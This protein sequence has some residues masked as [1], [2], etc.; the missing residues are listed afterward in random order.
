[1]NAKSV[2]SK[3]TGRRGW[4]YRFTDPARGG[5][6]HKVIWMTERREADR[7]F[8]EFL[9]GRE[10]TAAARPWLEAG[11][12]YA[13][14]WNY[15]RAVSYIAH[16][17]VQFKG[18]LPRAERQFVFV[19]DQGFVH[20]LFDL[21]STYQF[22]RTAVDVTSLKGNAPGPDGKTFYL[23]FQRNDLGESQIQK[24]KKALRSGT[25]RPGGW[26]LCRYGWGTKPAS[27]TSPTS[28]TVS[29]SAL[30]LQC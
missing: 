21:V 15:A 29:W 24:L 19:T 20:T 1:M 3:K 26:R 8:K 23:E 28:E 18:Y 27:C 12:K 11:Y 4:N 10:G 17:A 14:Q 22:I 7:A 6:T 30:S 5:R 13:Y 9:D 16:R 25:Y 2:R